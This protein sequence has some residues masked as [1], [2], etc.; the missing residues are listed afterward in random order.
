MKKEFIK[1]IHNVSLSITLKE[2]EVN[3][4]NIDDYLDS[5][6]D[7]IYKNYN[8]SFE[9]INQE[10]E[11]EEYFHVEFEF[12]IDAC[13][14]H[15]DGNLIDPPEDD[16]EFDEELDNLDTILKKAFPNMSFNVM[17]DGDYEI[18]D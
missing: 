10:V 2:G 6:E 17:Y 8:S 1:T 12:L 4:N 14:T 9:R 15:Y 3:E 18:K 13:H 11:N 5:I 7:I 16:V